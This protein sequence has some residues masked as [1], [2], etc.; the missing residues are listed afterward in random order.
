MGHRKRSPDALVAGSSM[1]PKDL[2]GHIDPNT[3]I[4]NGPIS[5]LHLK[6]S[7]EVDFALGKLLKRATEP[8]DLSHFIVRAGTILQLVLLLELYPRKFCGLRRLRIFGQRNKLKA[9]RSKGA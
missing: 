9:N 1:T 3:R 4:D 6:R 7:V 8:E 2:V 5:D